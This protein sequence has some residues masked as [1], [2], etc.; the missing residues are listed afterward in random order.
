M[1]PVGGVERG[2]RV[3]ALRAIDASACR[4]SWRPLGRCRLRRQAQAWPVSPHRVVRQ[5]RGRRSTGPGASLAVAAAA[6]TTPLLAASSGRP[7]PAARR[8]APPGRPRPAADRLNAAIVPAASW[9]RRLNRRSTA[10]W[11]RRRAGW[12]TAATAR[13]AAAPPDWSPGAA[14]GPARA[15]PRHTPDPAAPSAA[16][17]PG[18]G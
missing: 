16:R 14:A 8:S 3:G 6:T 12:N 9:R 10:A 4:R 17:R 18:C 11:M 2:R 13:V 5:D 1:A 7:R 15:R